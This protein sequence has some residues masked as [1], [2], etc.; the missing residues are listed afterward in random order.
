MRNA[1]LL[2]PA[3]VFAFSALAPAEVIAQHAEVSR[4]D[5]EAQKKSDSQSKG[6]QACNCSAPPN[7]NLPADLP[8]TS[9]GLSTCG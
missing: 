1:I 7:I 8:H 9:V 5:L 2:F 3:L 6:A 4:P